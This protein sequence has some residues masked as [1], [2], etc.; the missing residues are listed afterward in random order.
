MSPVSNI[1]VDN[2][3]NRTSVVQRDILVFLDDYPPPDSSYIGHL[4]RTR[5]IVDALGRHRD[6]AAYASVS[7]SLRR[8]WEAGR[9]NAYQGV[10]ASP[11][12]GHRWSARAA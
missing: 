9:I 11:G 7:R 4:P 1:A 6:K 8:L 3:T 2:V 10:M 12:Y 5:D